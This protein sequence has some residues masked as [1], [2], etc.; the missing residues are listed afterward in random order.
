MLKHVLNPPNWFTA[1]S[2]FCS[3]FAMSRVTGSVADGRDIRTACIL[4][5]LGGVFDLLD[6]RV[7]RITRRDS[8]FGSQLDSIADILGFGLAPAVIAWAW[9]L[10][11]LGPVGVGVSFWYVV[12]AAFR[13]ARFNVDATEQHWPRHGHSQGLTTTMAGGSLVTF[14][15]VAN[16]YLAG[17]FEPGRWPQY[18]LHA[19]LSILMVAL[20]ALMT[21]S[22]PFRN[23]RDLRQSRRSR[24]LLAVF[25]LSCLAGAV[26]FDPS[27]WWGVGAALYLTAGLVDGLVSML[28]FREDRT[29]DPEGT[30][31]LP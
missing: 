10:R 1:A 31:Q 13:L 28:F 11:D 21:S 20:G 2:I 8:A 6:G 22:V 23:F 27:M 30:P 12:C 9:L 15:W 18:Q 5:I 25:L 16:G 29:A 4:V 14:V 3:V 19:G 17:W 7:A 24:H 26:V